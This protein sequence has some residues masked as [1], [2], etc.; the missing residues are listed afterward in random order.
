MFTISVMCGSALYINNI[1]AREKQERV[2]KIP[3]TTSELFGSGNVLF[4]GFSI[5]EG[6]KIRTI[7][8]LFATRWF[9][10]YC[11]LGFRKWPSFEEKVA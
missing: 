2:Q 10:E 8:G 4:V 1:Y 6:L 7:S 5:L 9:S 3:P 11:N